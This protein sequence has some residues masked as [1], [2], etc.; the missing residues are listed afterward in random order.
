MGSANNNDSGVEMNA[1]AGGSLEDLSALEEPAEPMGT[2]GLSALRK[3]EN[4]RIDKLKQ[5]RKPLLGKGLK[6]P[7]ISGTGTCA[8]PGKMAKPEEDQSRISRRQ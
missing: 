7:S 3:L 6:L 5:L 8:R 1:N 4:L 2:S